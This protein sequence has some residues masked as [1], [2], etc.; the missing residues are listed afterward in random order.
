[1]G[2]SATAA[3]SGGLEFPLPHQCYLSLGSTWP[4]PRLSDVYAR[5]FQAEGAPEKDGDHTIQ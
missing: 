1:M 3:L 2:L 5:H 4:L